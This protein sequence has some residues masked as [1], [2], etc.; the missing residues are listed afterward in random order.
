[1]KILNAIHSQN[2][3]GV[4]QVFCDYTKVLF[5]LGYDVSLLISDNNKVDYR[6]LKTSRI[7]KLKNL[8]PIFDFFHLLIIIFRLKPDLII[9]HSP[10]I[11]SIT[12]ALKILQKIK[13]VK[14]KTIAL[15]H[16]IS[17]KK[18]LNCNYIFNINRQIADSVIDS[19]FDK[20]KVF[21]VEN[22]I[23]ITEKYQIK[24]LQSPIVISIFARLEMRKGFDILIK[25]CK[26]LAESGVDF[27]LKIG[28]FEMSLTWSDIKKQCQENGILDK[29]NFYGVVADKKNFFSDV[30]ILCV[31]SREE[32]F[33]LV[34]LEG[35]LHST[36]VLSSKTDGG[37]LLIKNEENGFL[38]NIAD[39]KN[40]AEK[41]IEITFKKENYHQYTKNAYN[42][43][44]ENY[45]LDALS[46]K[47]S[48]H[49]EKII[50]DKL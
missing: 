4:N 32:P 10:R 13:I 25:S 23:E 18:S 46:K 41:I 3:G 44:V 43:M 9:C 40:L 33:G 29:V 24:K 50:A 36:L 31:P 8:S 12:R 14:V 1:M 30:D 22:A 38:F 26:I 16:G 7:F 39:E 21:T 5:D 6:D 35:F 47:L 34:I 49:L 42:F 19:G 11:M 48:K 20:N 45:S 27:R 2:I 37:N 15:N 28:G 17:F